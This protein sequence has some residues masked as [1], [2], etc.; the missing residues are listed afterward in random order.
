MGRRRL[1]LVMNPDLSIF[2]GTRETSISLF[3]D[4]SIYRD[5]DIWNLSTRNLFYVQVRELENLESVKEILLS[6]LISFV[7]LELQS[8]LKFK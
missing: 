8:C 1:S 7:L 4:L 6:V 2:V 5:E 3:V